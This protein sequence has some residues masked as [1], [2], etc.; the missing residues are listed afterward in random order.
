MGTKEKDRTLEIDNEETETT[1]ESS[2]VIAKYEEFFEESKKHMESQRER[3]RKNEVLYNNKIE[4]PGPARATKLKFNIPLAIIETELPIISDY[5]PTFDVMP[6]EENDVF[7]ADMIT[8]RKNHIEKETKLSKLML[9]AVKDSLI[10]SNGITSVFPKKN[11]SDEYDG[12]E[13]SSVDLFT[14]F[15]AP[16]ATGMDIRSQARYHI[17]ATPMHVDEIKREYDV[18]IEPEGYLDEFRAFHI[19]NVGGI[20]G[21]DT[22]TLCNSALV[23]ECYAMDEGTEKYPNGRMVIWANGKIIS[24]MA[25]PF[26]RI[27][28]FMIGNYKT[29]HSLFGIGET[30]LVSTQTKAI[31]QVMSSLADV[32]NKTGNPI[33]K[34]T[35]SLWS[36]LKTKISGTPGEEVIV[37]KASDLT[38]D[39]PPNVPAHTF[40][41]IEL[42]LRL[43]DVVSGVHDVIEGKKPTG[44]T[45][46]AAII[47]LQEAAQARVRF[48]INNEITQYIE[49]MGTFIIWILQTYDEEV[50]SVRE[51]DEYGKKK[52]PEYDP[53]GIFDVQGLRE[54]DEGFDE[55][56]AQSMKDSHFDIE[57]VGGVRLPSG[58]VANE[59][60]ALELFKE[61][62]YGI[63]PTVMALSE[64][65]KGDL[66]DDYNE[67]QGVQQI[68][69][70]QEKLNEAFKE[71]EKLIGI[72]LKSPE[73]WSGGL[74]EGKL[75]EMLQ[76]FPEFLNSDEFEALPDELKKR[77]LLIFLEEKNESEMQQSLS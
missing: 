1:E 63:K 64:P 51:I 59:Q 72:A 36:Q 3:W 24:D 49:D 16:G 44:I 21:S 47:A 68:I 9:E 29:A 2:G 45:A 58:R 43:T 71:F 39:T 14:W 5:L 41:F 66:I 46:A 69:E 60:R 35:R 7:F 54:G 11:S 26:E 70:R 25:I 48:K 17:F 50:I 56:T 38:W 33:R 62:I 8:K 12:I 65:N 15:P 53:V 13:I 52:F 42:L 73:E 40:G 67:R 27:P 37:D 77:L 30:E 18:D 74:D 61:G 34:I 31:N 32:I 10:Y 19:V 75:A 22:D 55:T 20:T 28:Y 76:E 23:K 4:V 6:R 57:I